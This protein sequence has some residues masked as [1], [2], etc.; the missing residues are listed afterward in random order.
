MVSV[1]ALKSELA[2]RR[3]MPLTEVRN[4]AV[5]W[6]VSSLALWISVVIV[7]MHLMEH[8]SAWIRLYDVFTALVLIVCGIT[9]SVL[10]WLR[11][12]DWRF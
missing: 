10:A 11:L 6:S 7:V 1:E 4:V 3:A 8:N 5:K 12:R 2:R 9:A